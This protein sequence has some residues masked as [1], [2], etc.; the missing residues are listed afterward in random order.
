[1]V[2]RTSLR[3]IPI[4][5]LHIK[6]GRVITLLGFVVVANRRYRS[7]RSFERNCDLDEAAGAADAIA[8][9][10]GGSLCGMC[11]VG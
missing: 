1:M 10:G 5:I 3:L 2:F 8:C 9:P 11:C 7:L 6:K 4:Q